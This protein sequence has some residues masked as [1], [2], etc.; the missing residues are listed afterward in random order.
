MGVVKMHFSS[1]VYCENNERERLQSLFDQCFLNGDKENLRE[2]YKKL[3][4]IELNADINFNHEAVNIS[5]LAESI[6]LACDIIIAETGTSIIY[7]GNDTCPAL[8][9]QRFL[10]KALLNLIS[11]AYLYGCEN[12]ITIKTIETKNH[13]RLEVQNGGSFINNNNGQGLQFVREFCKKSNGK[14]FIEQSPTH[15]CAIMI[16]EKLQNYN[17]LQEFDFYSLLNDRLSPLYVELFG[18]DYH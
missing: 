14:F 15:T 16:F 2:Q 8:C 12:L 6:S 17:K 4:Q 9:N 5:N 13:I 1:I 11:N 3:R 7:C 10:T 18:M